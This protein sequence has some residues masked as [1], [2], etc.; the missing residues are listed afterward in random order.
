MQNQSRGCQELP[1]NSPFNIPVNTLPVDSH[2]ARWLTRVSE[3]GTQYPD[4][5][6]N[7]KFYPQ[8][9]GLYD[10]PVTN[11][12]QQQL[13]HF[14]YPAN[15][16]GYQD[17][18]FP[19]PPERTLLMESGRSVDAHNTGDRHL[20]TMNSSTC[21][22]TEIYNLYV[23]F[24]TATF[25][26]GNP[27]SVTWTTNTVWPIPQNYSVYIS[28]ATGAWA[29][30]NG[31]W[32]LTITGA[33]SGTLPFDSSQWGAPPAGTAVT[34][35]PS[36]YAG[37][38]YNSQGGQQFSSKSY[39]QLGGVDAAGMPMSAL[40]LKL[41]EWYAATQAGRSD[42]GHALRTTMSNSYLSARNIWP[43]TLY[44]LS[45]AGFQNKLLSAIN[46]TTT[47][48]TAQSDISQSNPCDN[49]T[50][51]PGCQFNI[52]IFGLTGAW[53]AANGDQTATAIDNTHFSVALNSS[54]WGQMPAGYGV[55]FVDDF[56]PYG[57]TVRLSSSVDLNQ[58]CTSTDLTNWC[59]YAKVYLATLQKYGMVVA[60]GTTPS[61]NWDNGTVSSEFHPNVLVDAASNITQWAAIQP[62]EGHLEVVNRSSQQLSTNLNSYQQT[63]TNRTY[64]TACGSSGCASE[65]VILQ[66]TTI[67]TDRERLTITAGTSYPMN[68]WVNGNVST[69]VSYA[70]NS[71]IPGATVSST[72]VVTMP[73]CT[74]K[75]QG[76][77]TVTSSADP[78]ALPLYVEVG[79]L[80]ISSDGSY[81][82]A[83]GNYTGDYVDSTGQT[84][85]GSWQ[86]NGFNNSYEAPGIWWATQNGSWQ[87]YEPC[88]NDTWS[89]ADSQLYSR[90]T[91][92]NEDTRVDVILPNGNYN[93]TLYGEPG[94][95]GFGSNGTCGNSAGQNIFDWVVQGQT[96]GSWM[97]GYVLAGMQSY[98]GYTVSA[99]TTVTDNVLATIGR[100][101][102]PS[103]YGA[104]WS[105]LLITPGNQ[106][107]HVTTGSLPGASV[108]T[109]YSAAVTAAGGTP[110]YSWG[111]ANGSSPLP[112]GLNINPSSGLISG[113]PS[114]T[115]TY[116]FTV[117][118]TDSA[119][120][121]ATRNLSILVSGQGG[122]SI[123]ASPFAVSGAQGSQARWTVSTTVNNGFNNSIALSASGLPS[124]ATVS[125]NPST[126]SAPGS[127]SATMT[128]A[129]ASN[130]PTGTYAI[131][132]TGNGGG[133]Q[134]STV[135]TLKVT[136]GTGSFSI[137]AS[138]SSL[139]VAQGSQG[140]STITTTISGN[141][142]SAIALS[143]TGMP[144]GVNVS[145]N[146]SAIAAP[147]NGTATMTIT[148]ASSAP[149]GTYTFTVSGNGGGIQQNATITL[150]IM[151]AP[152]FTISASPNSLSVAQGNHGNSTI[153]TTAMNGF[154]NS[155]T[156]SASGLPSGAGA[157]FNPGTISAPGSGSST[158]TIS[159]GSS[160]PAGTY[161][162]TIKGSGGGLQVSTTVT[163]TVTGSA[164]FT[165]SAT[166]PSQTVSRGG[167]TAYTTSLTAVNGFN[168][169][170]SLSVSGC[171]YFA[172]CSF[173]P[174]S[175][176]PP[177]SSTL[178]VSTN[179]YTPTGAYTLTITGT[180]GSLRHSTTVSLTV[181][182]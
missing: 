98:N 159:V 16:N 173:S 52:T 90:S 59:P 100:M 165:L 140:T 91:D 31:N 74:T 80:P 109:L 22:G 76:M 145:F 3:D 127:G 19:I 107:L 64:V 136:A 72:G 176:T 58:L 110:P 36:P 177:G 87:G 48:F 9:L 96:A 10:N 174:R 151:G 92:L 103:V 161:P 73:N 156:L 20:F 5:D 142:N 86:N 106:Q 111:L 160:T 125:F 51:T 63:N 68:V 154:N 43:A 170:V 114:A 97:D 99:P 138:P 162:I 115:G 120:N 166:P 163:L 25:T 93:L 57:A 155:I 38:N 175:L 133:I 124:G 121:T 82:L 42:L 164:D 62:I 11:S 118:V 89:G 49:Y 83:L 39:A 149:T 41:E 33:N 8:L 88:D 79:C 105:S 179:T 130:T 104:S 78:Q 132:I 158:L 172:T 157:S 23:D 75:Q 46:G 53:A 61:D 123:L 171:P 15:S 94:F 150:T 34:S 85:F 50:Y 134:Q 29:A 129:L 122:F 95:G 147:G 2:S 141:F 181:I 113:T 55:Y 65:D 18:N 102:M 117:Q 153:T 45:V 116:S 77:I 54:S 137:S 37:P 24:R 67:G 146:P 27:T 12:T 108:G 14:Y 148:V 84:W 112:P 71:G 139:S 40:S 28:G 81:R 152:S 56:F 13:M 144:P 168:S 7:I 35:L 30:A 119:S 70:I 47:T 6:H 26:P 126:L 69:A 17:T 44:A 135:T 128:V 21:T 32:R 66:G 60:D 169:N 178:T 101:R 167:H 180:S 143:A 131:T 1:N 182:H 4:P